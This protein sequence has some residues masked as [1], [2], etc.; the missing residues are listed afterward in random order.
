MLEV[1]SVG[2]G[3]LFRAKGKKSGLYLSMDKNGR[4]YGAVSRRY[5]TQDLQRVQR[6]ENCLLNIKI[7][8]NDMY[9]RNEE[10]ATV[11]DN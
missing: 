7:I 5:T 2:S 3:G 4:F 8:L 6:Y 11:H 10:F 9:I 1:E